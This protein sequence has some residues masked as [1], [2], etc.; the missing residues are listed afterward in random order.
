MVD[1]PRSPPHRNKNGCVPPRDPSN[2]SPPVIQFDDLV[3]NRP[4]AS[5]QR[6]RRQKMPLL[7]EDIRTPR[8]LGGKDL[9][10]RL[11][12]FPMKFKCALDKIRDERRR[13]ALSPRVRHIVKRKDKHKDAGRDSLDTL[14]EQIGREYA[15]LHPTVKRPPLPPKR[16]PTAHRRSSLY[17]PPFASDPVQLPF[18]IAPLPPPPPPTPV[19][20]EVNI[21]VELDTL[22]DILGLIEKYPLEA[23]VKY[24]IDMTAMH[25]I[26]DP[27]SRLD[28]MIGMHSLKRSIVDQVVYFVQNLHLN[29]NSR[30]QDF[31]HTVIYGPPGS[32]KTEVAKLMGGIFSSLGVL[33]EKKFKKVTRTDLIAGYLG[34]TAIKTTKVVKEAL[35]GVLFID[36]A[37]ALGNMEKRDSFAKECIDTLCEAL[38]DHKEELMVIVAGYEDNLNKCFFSYN[39]GLNS[40][41]P[42]R[43]KT[44]DYGA[45][46]MRLIFEKKVKDA[47]W[48]FEDKLSTAWFKEK[49]GYFKFFGRDM[50]TL[51]AKTKIAHAKRVFC[52]PKEA[53]TILS[54][55]DIQRGFASFIANEEVKKRKL[56]AD[57]GDISMLYM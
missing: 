55:D 40:R 27:V 16:R 13:N 46:E 50:E 20:R 5:L 3:R 18:A 57:G 6:W 54:K 10:E 11:R 41:F 34:Q 35:G 48:S 38:S 43:F 56:E 47:G 49:M 24:N 21:D 25:N 23:G 26:K 32:G 12:L 36:E 19:A 8:R 1:G 33:K 9:N 29:S 4:L 28:A 14:L 42:W 7:L 52:K 31:M 17:I 44:D 37:Y 22:S 39:Q 30:G 51:F 15:N 53:K 2:A 45:K